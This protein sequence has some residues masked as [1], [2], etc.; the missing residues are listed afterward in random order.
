MNYELLKVLLKIALF[1]SSVLNIK[2]QAANVR[3][4]FVKG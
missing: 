1:E 3:T 2:P 4:S